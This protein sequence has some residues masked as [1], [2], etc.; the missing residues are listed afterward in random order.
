MKKEDQG[1]Y[2][3]VREK[4]FKYFHVSQMTFSRMIDEL[5]RKPGERWVA[6]GQRIL[7]LV[8]RWSSHCETI[9]EVCELFTLDKLLKIM[10]RQIAVKVKEK[11]PEVLEKTAEWADDIW[12]SLDWRYEVMPNKDK[13]KK[14]HKFVKPLQSE[15][16]FKHSNVNDREPEKNEKHNKSDKSKVD[17]MKIQ[18]YM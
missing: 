15:S 18:C 4:L 5:E 1:D 16:S 7:R 3:R 2:L 13:V 8:K 11:R 12:D 6:C 9:E 17:K 10:P 14:L